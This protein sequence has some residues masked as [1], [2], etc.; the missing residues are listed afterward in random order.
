MAAWLFGVFG[1]RAFGLCLPGIRA[2]A[3][4][5]V[6]PLLILSAGLTSMP[7]ASQDVES[8]RLADF[9]DIDRLALTLVN[10]IKSESRVALLPLDR[11]IGLPEAPH[12]RFYDSLANALRRAAL[13]RAIT[14][15][16][17]PRQREIY[18]HLVDTFEEDLDEK[19][20]SILK[21][22]KADYVVICLWEADD[23]SGF[24]LSCVSSGV[25][26]I[27]R[28]AGDN[29]RFQ[30]INEDEYLEFIVSRL[31][32]SVLGNRDLEHVSEVQIHDLRFG[33]PTE[34]T[35]FV[36]D[37]VQR[38][39][40]EVAGEQIL[41]GSTAGYGKSHHLEGEVSHPDDGRVRLLIR[42]FE[43]EGSNGNRRFVT[44]DAVSLAVASF[45][46]NLRPLEISHVDEA[47]RTT[48]RTSIRARPG[49]HV[50]LDTLQS[51]EEVH[52]T[53][54]VK[55]RNGTEWLRIELEDETT[56]F[57]LA[58]SL[59][60]GRSS[61][62]DP[63][64]E[65]P[66]GE[67]LVGEDCP[68]SK[69][70]RLA[71][72][73]IC[74]TPA[75]W[76]LLSED[77]LKAEKYEQLL[78]EAKSHIARH[79]SLQPL[80]RVRDQ[81]VSGL[82]SRIRVETK[83]DAR[84]ELPRIT[85]IEES[86]GDWA[87]LL[88]L[89]AR[90][91][92][93]LRDYSSEKAAHERWLDV[94]PESH[95]GRK[96]VWS[97]FMLAQEVVADGERFAAALGRPPSRHA[98][99]ESAGWTD[100]HHAALLN[101]PGVVHALIEAG[102]NADSPLVEGTQF[103]GAL[104]QTLGDLGHGG[105][106]DYWNADGETPLMIAAFANSREASESLLDRGASLAARN[107]RGSTPLHFAALSD[108]RATAGFL[109][110]RD[111][112]AHAEDE[113]GFTPLHRA[114]S[115]DA[116]QVAEL[117]L[118]HDDE[119]HAKSAHGKTPLHRAAWHG[120]IEVARLLVERG[121]DI[122]AR[123]NDGDT[124]LHNAASA[125][126][127]EV[128][129]LLLDRGAD[130]DAKN[131]QG[132]TPLHRAAWR[133]FF[134]TARL[135][136]ER[137]ADVTTQANDGGTPLHF[138][139]RGNAPGVAE[140][141]LDR[142]AVIDAKDK[143]GRMPL[144]RVAR[145]DAVET[146]SLLVDW[147]ANVRARANDGSTPLHLA[148]RWDAPG[149]AELLLERGAEVGA[150]N[151]QGQ[152]PLETAEEARSGAV[153]EL[154]VRHLDH[155]AF[156][157]AKRLNT[158]SGYDAYLETYSK[159]LHAVEARAMRAAA[160]NREEDH[161]AFAPA[162][163]LDTVASFDTYLDSYPRGLHAEE[164]RV[165]RA[166][167][168]VREE[169]RAAFAR[170][171][172]LDT[173]PGYDEYLSKY[174]EGLHAD[175]ARELRA[176]VKNREEDRAA[177]ARAKRL[178]TVTGYDAYLASYSEGLHANRAHAL[179]ASAKDREEDD[180]AFARARQLDTVAGYDRY[181]ESHLTGRHVVEARRLR[182]A[183]ARREDA[184][185]FVRAKRRDTVA[186][187]D[188][189]L[190]SYSEGLHAE[191]ARVLRAAAGFREEDAATFARVKRLDT[192]AGYDEYL[193]S[194]PEGSNVAKV[195]QLREVALR[196]E[197]TAAFSRAKSLDTVAAY[198][199]Y[200]GSY[201]EGL[202]A[203]QARRLRAVAR[204]R[205][206][207]AEAFAH[208]KRWGTVASYDEYLES[209]PQGHHVVEA[210][211]LRAAAKS[212]AEDVAAFAH[213]KGLDTVAGYDEYLA[214]FPGGRHLTES[215]RLRAGVV[216]RETDD[217]AFALAK[218]LDTVAA[219]D[220]Y[221]GT[222]SNGLHAD[223]ARR[224]R[225]VAL[226][227]ADDVAFAHA[228][229]LDTIA[230][231]DAYL[232]SHPGGRHVAEA[233]RLR[234]AASKV[235]RVGQVFRDCDHCPE[236]VV[237]PPGTY[238][239]G[240]PASEE[241]RDEDEGP[242]HRVVV[243]NAIAVGTAEVTR[244]EYARFFRET[245][246]SG[247]DSCRT[248]EGEQWKQRSGRDWRDP[249]YDQTDRHPAVCVNW[250]DAQR[251][252]AWL[253]RE[254]GEAYRLPSESEWEYAARGG[255]D[256]S[257]HWGD[258]SRFQCRYANGADEALK[259][260]YRD[261]REAIGSCGDRHV[262]TAPAKRYAKNGFG[263]FDVLGNVWEWTADCGNDRYDE[264][265]GDG[266]DWARGKCSLRVLRGGSWYSEPSSLRSANRLLNRAGLRNG[267]VGFR[268]VR[269]LRPAEQPVLDIGAA[270]AGAE[271][272][273]FTRAATRNTVES[274]DEYLRLSPEGRHAER[275]RR[276]RDRAFRHLRAGG[277]FRDCTD[278][279]EMAV[280]PMGSFEMGSPADEAGRY[281]DEDPV[282]RVTLGGSFAVGVHEVTRRQYAAFVHES[283]RAAG[284]SCFVY[285]E[286]KWK[287]RSDRS[288][289]DPGYGQ[290]GDHPAVCVSW[291][292]AVA[293]AEWLSRKAG[294][295]YRLPSESEWE[296]AARGGTRASRHFGDDA[297]KQC[298]YAN[299]ADETAKRREAGLTTVAPCRD[300][301]LVTAPAGRFE[302]NGYGLHDVLGNA[303]EWTRD[304]WN[305]GHGGASNDGLARERGDCT[306]RILRGGSWSSFP[307]FLRSARRHK[308]AAD[309]RV[310]DVGFRV[311][312]ALPFAA[313]DAAFWRA[314][315]EG[316]AK[317]YEDYLKSYPQGRHVVEAKRVLSGPKDGE[318]FRDCAE[319]PEMVVVPAGTFVMG[320]PPEERDRDRDE[321]PEHRVNIEKRF[322]VGVH[323][324]TF[325]EWD[326][327]AD[328]G[329]C[330][331]Y[332][333]QDRGWGRGRNPV[334]FV[335]WN[336][337]RSYVEWLSR[338]TGEDYRLPS[339]SEWEY[340]ARAGRRTRYAWGD[341]VGRGRANCEVCGSRWD[342]KRVAPVGSFPP[343]AFGVHDVHGN[344]SEWV[345]DCW[346]SGYSGAPADG[347]A[348]DRANCP[349]RVLRG[350]AWN[351]QARYLRSAN[352]SR[353][354]PGKRA[355]GFGFRVAR[356]LR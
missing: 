310:N 99:E 197:D 323:E 54:K 94:A 166:V 117:L 265:P 25:E 183:A 35:D 65:W 80:V 329:G 31:T 204:S 159:G 107:T 3:H 209:Y 292:D 4:F 101:R 158:V 71:D 242:R 346:A 354:D 74:A 149:V 162:K 132:K 20:M 186:A 146:A 178:N 215:R 157:R 198:D 300:G 229:R 163:R 351:D 334:V 316:S 315:N 137:G 201:P 17:G 189:Y 119:A 291:A 161:V 200:L 8:Q 49:S 309:I 123:E 75:D 68:E 282:R 133:N 228:K 343:N 239:M 331:R 48:T 184:A 206:A 231:Y 226:R 102:M 6:L 40:M 136:V 118:D 57:V 319:C 139:A 12:Q 279:P 303:W 21:R 246:H 356:S 155:A 16:A 97:A 73:A 225:A 63:E 79:G 66:G 70:I 179:R 353:S 230:G 216:A 240:S 187:Y 148:A 258:G 188:D 47:R 208:A 19:L 195:R 256:T 243:A 1:R 64:K 82:V 69:P 29:V 26:A 270:I 91:H 324:V 87:D 272:E 130:L 56:G 280:V 232:G 78:V 262:H 24:T 326:A 227:K 234:D 171:K 45:P 37:L 181:R 257:R 59:S 217:A 38:E 39:A 122:H 62:A 249:G 98:K 349:R 111:A 322:A 134:V 105:E 259:N 110:E 347:T 90:A 306:R 241:G 113:E 28:L 248:F 245:G 180:A 58:S 278:C 104:K 307:R 23:P 138:A 218:R 89:K 260:R 330:N 27:D 337:V 83:A 261:R 223:E 205:E 273:T 251:Y 327:C 336:D 348:L 14:M 295:R 11:R 50:R 320:S 214:T 145:R 167:A 318:T 298:R 144:H 116:H 126:A 34:L 283:G 301:Y 100:L 237:I 213:A 192:V 176:A 18:R 268:V 154:L 314:K 121:A 196:N 254:T 222:Y 112:D 33:G 135:L 253:S 296:Y 352:R 168:K 267:N 355:P 269:E 305:F 250:D 190:R 165:L 55:G 341:E 10:S 72:K 156:S 128:A 86:V 88:R 109:L 313:D 284:D 277:V 308:N 131:E 67:P 339:E 164:A 235:K 22:A 281:A 114:A 286:G 43:G 345:E 7:A 84:R 244:A 5:A 77:D 332:R 342:D 289:R 108:A 140:L 325:E 175:V 76:A 160:K 312:R 297:S 233:G 52:V 185:A 2:T 271:D 340:V 143:Q 129:E 174:R 203:E 172:N 182:A 173:V 42:L 106:F 120:A 15:V 285:E 51:G 338:K 141:L 275:A 61:S 333:P 36:S 93:L 169:D 236:L 219:Y 46:S 290:T 287:E 92:R 221:L 142:G 299:G 177:F 151:E 293:Y 263:L 207:D 81:A 124:P 317:S 153:M 350:G 44:S 95:P 199:G 193:A 344:A 255:T 252:V 264:A 30:W 321:G 276:L 127:R 103:G 202:H 60:G 212:R 328:Q 32:R 147:D 194:F 220:Q 294:A 170:A 274:Y 9:G 266:S 238:R 150:K 41:P 115:V 210:R 53:A 304:C 211:R 311:A 288:W 96:E 152:T 191:D 335:S 247:D 13:N 85:R 125:G 224:H 302:P